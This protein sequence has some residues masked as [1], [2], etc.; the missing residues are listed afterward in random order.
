M[1]TSNFLKQLFA[2]FGT[3]IAFSTSYH[4]Q[5]DG[6]IERVKQILEDMLRM[7]VMQ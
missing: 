3:H 5:T 6:K 1:F 7:Q 4:P 2:S